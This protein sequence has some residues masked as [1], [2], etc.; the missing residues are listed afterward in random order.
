MSSTWSCGCGQEHWA[1]RAQCRACGKV[2]DR[3]RE[4]SKRRGRNRGARDAGAHAGRLQTGIMDSMHQAAAREQNARPR[5]PRE[6]QP[7]HA[8]WADLSPPSV[9]SP[10]QPVHP[11]GARAASRS[12]SRPR[13]DASPPPRHLTPTRGAPMT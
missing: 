11:H 3:T 13:R 12:A 10:P 8:G 2:R 5:Q 6:R 1:S 4:K 7:S 9:Q